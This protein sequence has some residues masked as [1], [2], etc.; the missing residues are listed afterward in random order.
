MA[1]P[2]LLE[3]WE[4]LMNVKASMVFVQRMKTKC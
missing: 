1:L 2:L 3:K 4:A